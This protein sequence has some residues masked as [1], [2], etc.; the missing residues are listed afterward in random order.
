MYIRI[1]LYMAITILIGA[2]GYSLMKQRAYNT[3]GNK[4]LVILGVWIIIGSALLAALLIFLAEIFLWRNEPT[5]STLVCL[6]SLVVF[7][8]GFY[9]ISRQIQ[10][11][12]TEIRLYRRKQAQG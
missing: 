1:L 7:A 12:I 6:R 11:D 5:L 4:W 9:L 3:T 8:A 2:I 10:K